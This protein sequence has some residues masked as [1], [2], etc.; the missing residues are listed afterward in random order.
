MRFIF[1]FNQNRKVILT[2]HLRIPTNPSKNGAVL[3]VNGQINT[4][5]PFTAVLL[6]AVERYTH[7]QLCNNMHSFC[8]WPRVAIS[9]VVHHLLPLFM[10]K[11][12]VSISMKFG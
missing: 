2:L 4:R 6:F 9:A 5:R 7:C 3:L 8:M 1:S 11:R 12:I 10:P